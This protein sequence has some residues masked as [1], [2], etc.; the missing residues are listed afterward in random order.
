MVLDL[1]DR[2][3]VGDRGEQP[4]VG[5]RAGTGEHVDGERSP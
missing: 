1:C 4:Q 2:G 5:A 3:R